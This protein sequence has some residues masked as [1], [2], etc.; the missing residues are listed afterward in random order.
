MV[1]TLPTLVYP[2]KKDPAQTNRP[3]P[4]IFFRVVT[5]VTNCFRGRYLAI[6]I[7]AVI[8]TYATV[9][10][11][12]D[13]SYFLATRRS[14]LHALFFP[15]LMAGSLLPVLGPL[16]LLLIGYL[17]KNKS[18][19]RNAWALGQATLLG[20][21]L[22]SFYK[23]F[24]GR[25]QP[26]MKNVTVDISHT[27][28]FGVLRGGIFWGWPS[29]HTTIAFAT[30]ITA[31]WLYR[32]NRPIPLLAVIY[33]TYVGIGVATVGIHWLSEALAG[34]LI[35]TVIGIQVGKSFEENFALKK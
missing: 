24:T 30:A 25:L 20:S 4:T 2:R 8:L 28:R 15:A 17:R 33:A 19:I 11:G 9:V 22:S 23:V 21:A 5:T 13:W 27:F 10:S 32:K 1:Y 35:G 29:S 14:T 12:L 34:A 31:A 3:M 26:N 7:T 6:Q 16:V 18:L